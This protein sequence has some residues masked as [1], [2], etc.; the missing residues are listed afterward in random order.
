MR[1]VSLLISLLICLL[2]PYAFARKNRSPLPKQNTADE[3]S[4]KSP[5]D[6]ET[7]FSPDEPCAIKL[8]KFIKSASTSIDIAIY[9]INEDR[10]VHALLVQ[11]KKVSVRIIVDRLQS[12][13]NRS[14]VALLQKAGIPLRFGHQRGIMHDKFT[15]VDGK[16][17]ETGSFNYTDHAESSN[18]EN[19][20]YLSTPQIAG[21]YKQRFEQM[22]SDS[23]PD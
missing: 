14:S 18:Q 13:G 9:S 4:V 15:I 1:N 20:I 10:V 19:Q 6:G 16:R 23:K 7:C 5:E 22:W 21:R 2:H 11:S 8:A 3:S 17:I 12:K